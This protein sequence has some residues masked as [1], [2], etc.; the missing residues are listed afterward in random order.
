MDLLKQKLRKAGLVPTRQRV[1]VLQSM[2]QRK[3]HPYVDLVL[4]DLRALL[5]SLSTDT[6]YRTLHAYAERGLIQRLALPIRRACFDGNVLSHDHFVC[7]RCELVL[8]LPPASPEQM[9][10]GVPM[11]RI[12][13]IHTVQQVSTGV[14]RDCAR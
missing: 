5:P 3:D 9:D 14:C 1:L 11:D 8:D 10:L 2:L 12:A 13:E 6:V 4:T 7:I